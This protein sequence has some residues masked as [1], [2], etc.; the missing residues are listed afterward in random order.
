MCVQDRPAAYIRQVCYVQYVTS[1]QH[2]KDT[3]W[4]SLNPTGSELSRRP[5][6]WPA[7][8]Q[9]KSKPGSTGVVPVRE[10][11]LRGCENELANGVLACQH[12]NNPLYRAYIGTHWAQRQHPMLFS[13]H[14][15]QQQ[16]GS[17]SQP[18]AQQHTCMP[19]PINHGRRRG[20][21]SAQPRRLLSL[22]ATGSLYLSYSGSM[23]S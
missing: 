5:P 14:T 2:I 11:T 22:Q 8:Q 6:S 23:R 19:P 16:R 15:K 20:E 10:H 12:T 1:G 17:A 4:G 21:W 18:T 13:K 3:I 7:T 9:T